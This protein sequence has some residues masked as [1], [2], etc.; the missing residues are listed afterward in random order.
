M[1]RYYNIADVVSALS[2]VFMLTEHVSVNRTPGPSHVRGAALSGGVDQP[3]GGDRT[4]DGAR[5]PHPH[6]PDCRTVSWPVCPSHSASPVVIEGS[7]SKLRRLA[8]DVLRLAANSL[9]HRLR[10]VA[11][12][13]MG[14]VCRTRDSSAIEPLP[15]GCIGHR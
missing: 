14:E 8:W 3:E 13:S 12:A 15:R 7:T 11:P 6:A 2:G 5:S 1:R 10:S 4:R 9:P